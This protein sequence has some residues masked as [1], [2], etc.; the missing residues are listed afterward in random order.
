MSGLK[1][2]H[3]YRRI[4]SDLT[5]A[6]STGGI[7]SIAAAF[8]MASLFLSHLSAYL[9]VNHSTEVIMDPSEGEHSMMVL[10]FDITLPKVGCAYASVDLYDQLGNTR[11]NVTGTT[12]EGVTAN[13]MMDLH[14]DGFTVSRTRVVTDDHTR[15]IAG[16][17]AAAPKAAAPRDDYHNHHTK[18]VAIK[19]YSQFPVSEHV[20]WKEDWNKE[21]YSVELTRDNF[22]KEVA[23]YAFAMVSFYAPWCHYCTQL[24]PVWE[25]ASGL[26]EKTTANF[27]D[28]EFDAGWHGFESRS[29]AMYLWEEFNGAHPEYP[30][31]LVDYLNAQRQEKNMPSLP[32][33]GNKEILMAKVDCTKQQRLCAQQR[34]MGYP[35]IRIYR[36]HQTTSVEEYQGDRTARAITKFVMTENPESLHTEV[37]VPE[38]ELKLREAAEQRIHEKM[39]EATSEGCNLVGSLR[40]RKVPGKLVFT[41]HS[42]DRSLDLSVLNTSH[43]IHHI[44]F[45]RP[46]EVRLNALEK[47][48][49]VQLLQDARDLASR[50][51]DGGDGSSQYHRAHMRGVKST[52]QA[53]VKGHV[54][55]IED[56]V[57]TLDETRFFSTEPMTMQTHHVKLV[58][59][60]LYLLGYDAFE[61]FQMQAF[62]GDYKKETNG[63]AGPH[64]H[65][66][67]NIAITY[68][69]SPLTTVVRE[70]R[71]SFSE[72]LTNLCAVIGGVFT[73]LG[74]LD[75]VVYHTAGLL[76]LRSLRGE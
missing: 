74:M 18:Q 8:I 43:V 10:D 53:R 4:H 30:V 12:I 48:Q 47:K 7:I 11:I 49:F 41:A 37:E 76:G 31:A 6:T 35:T 32:D 64:S 22:D 69:V 61:M 57:W 3:M 70:S 14:W 17:K 28:D 20:G 1:S 54:S 27:G 67:P 52:I 60:D 29:E 45:R 36:N 42:N 16:A 2:F 33:E 39:T 66:A 71:G 44:G 9:G 24:K 26:V 15:Y 56:N 23:S 59:S 13:E 62:S 51:A 5:K 34:I 63:E 75:N 55:G 73:V 21:V 68:E 25:H 72:F 38:E 40:V 19:E 46:E 65:N 50:T 58:R